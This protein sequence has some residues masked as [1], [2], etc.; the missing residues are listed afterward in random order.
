[1][2]NLNK[3][4]LDDETLEV[5]DTK[6]R[7]DIGDVSTLETTTKDNL[8]KALNEVFQ[9]ASDGKELIA[10]AITGK[11]ITTGKDA[12]FQTMADNIALIETGIKTDDATVTAAQ[13]LIGKVA[14]GADGRM[15]GTMADNGAV[16]STLDAGGSY[17][18]PIGFH[19]GSGKVTAKTLA[20]QTAGTATAAQ[21]LSGQTAWVG[22]AKITG[23]MANKAGTATAATGSLDATNS[24]VRLQIPSN[25]Y[26]DTSAYLYISYT[27]LASILGITA[28]KIVAGNTIL[29]IAG[30]GYGTWS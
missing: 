8:V 23:T 28:D 4:V 20:S 6:A 19:N 26:Y 22:G 1:M 9:S 29:G 14:Y 2:G 27:A 24:R 15:V 3:I 12:T 11:G 25:G 7:T 10:I 18:I 5:E 16:A 13:I 30:T 17:T 21:I